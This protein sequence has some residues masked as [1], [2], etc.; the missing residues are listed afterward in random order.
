MGRRGLV[1]TLKSAV[2]Q[3][4]HV[5]VKKNML[6]WPDLKG[7]LPCT[8]SWP[9]YW[10][11]S[12]G[13]MQT[14]REAGSKWTSGTT[15]EQNRALV[16]RPQE[17]QESHVTV[18]NADTHILNG[19]RQPF[20]RQFVHALHCHQHSGLRPVKQIPHGQ[21]RPGEVLGQNSEIEL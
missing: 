4:E 12:S 10:P 18:P 15:A 7:L 13:D 21:S 20:H 5:L 16:I 11:T 19:V 3:E 2:S 8:E 1:Q 9:D 14:S 6:N 17:S